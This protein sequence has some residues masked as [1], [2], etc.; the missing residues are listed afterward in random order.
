[1]I[2]VII[3]GGVLFIAAVVGF[4]G[5]IYASEERSEK[6]FCIGLMGALL[7]LLLGGNIYI[8]RPKLEES[9][10]ESFHKIIRMDLSGG[11]FKQIVILP[12]EKVI[13]IATIENLKIAKTYPDNTILRRYGYDQ[14]SGWI[15]YNNKDNFYNEIVLPTDERYEVAKEKIMEMK[16]TEPEKE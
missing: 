1:M 2:S 8:F 10:K 9:S 7:A 13:N 4:C 3:V 5:L 11:V 12:D 16:I 15:K 14:G 6:A